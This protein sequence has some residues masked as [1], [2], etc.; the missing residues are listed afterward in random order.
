M[1]DPRLLSVANPIPGNLC[2]KGQ[3]SSWITTDIYRNARPS[4]PQI[5]CSEGAG[6]LAID[7][8]V[9]AFLQPASY[10]FSSGSQ[11]VKVIIKNTGNATLTSM[12]V[13]I[14]LGG[15]NASTINWSGSLNACAVDTVTFTGSNQL[16]FAPGSNTLR[17]WVDSPNF[18]L[19]SNAIND[20]ISKTFC[21]PLAVG[22]YTIGTGGDFASF[23]AAASALNC[24]GLIG[25][26]PTV[27]NILSG[28][29]NE[30]LSLG[31]VPGT[32]AINTIT[33]QSQANNADSATLSFNATATSNYVV[34]LAS[35]S[36]VQFKDL[37]IQSLNSTAGTVFDLSGTI[38]YDTIINCKIVAPI[39]ATTATTAVLIFANGISGKL[40]YFANNIFTNGSYGIYLYGSS[41]TQAVDSSFI[42]NN[43]FT[44]VYYQSMAL[45]YTLNIKVRNN[46]IS[47]GAYVS[48]MGIY[49]INSAN[50]FEILNNRITTAGQ[51]GIYLSSVN[52]T[53]TL[54][55]N[56]RNNTVSGGTTGTYYGM[57]LG[58]CT[59]I[60]VYNNSVVGNSTATTSYACYTQFTGT[61]GT[62]VVFRNNIFSNNSVGTAITVGA[63]YVYNTLY[64][65]SNYNNLYCAGPNLVNVATPALTHQ[66]IYAWRAAST[67]EKNSISYKPGYTSN[68]NLVPNP[69]DSNA[70][71]INGHGVIIANNLTDILGNP[72]PLNVTQGVVDLGAYEFTPTS[73]P[74]AALTNI[75]QLAPDSTQIFMFAGDTVASIKWEPFTTP[76][77]NVT[78]RRYSGV[79]PN[80][81]D[82]NANNYMYF[83][84][85]VSGSYGFYFFTVNNYYKNEWIGRIPSETVLK[86]ATKDT[87]S[88]SSWTPFTFANSSVDTI[89]NIISLA[90]NNY[91][92]Y[93]YTGTD[94][95][96]P[97]PVKLVNFNV[98][99]VKN[100]AEINWSTSEEINNK[101]FDIER[102]S[103][104][105]NFEKINL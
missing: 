16:T 78:V 99:L 32:S 102:S 80:F 90:N 30:Q 79:R 40:N 50:A 5:G 98:R 83:Y 1:E 21:T 48:S 65:N 55:G 26:G 51:S 76:P 70:W 74:P 49:L 8:S 71:A 52:G 25:T 46:I 101:G 20:T 73:L 11:D 72:R 2:Q 12:N 89:R 56:I 35:T 41:L 15:L 64:L 36:F 33:F 82:T 19:D 24:G 57:Y 94:N 45:S 58:S 47:C 39:V 86:A 63:L 85:L 31:Y 87:T 97:L 81:I 96:N 14:S 18:L 104:G 7:A 60:N 77:S 100:N 22:T 13:T 29:Y 6:G 37:K 3:N 92:E 27:F 59:Y 67:Y 34:K 66:N 103:D 91:M 10:P 23:S 105:K 54:L 75:A 62:T 4:P 53:S 17:A 68:T 95:N 61:T 93:Y 9:K 43:T 69:L 44:N 88:F 38:S 42:L 84:T 28:T